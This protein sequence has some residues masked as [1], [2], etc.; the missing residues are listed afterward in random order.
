MEDDDE[1]GDLYTDVLR[2]FASSSSSS[3]PQPHQ[4]SAAPEQSLRR[5]ID[6]SLENDDDDAILGAP[7]SNPVPSSRARDETLAPAPTPGGA[8]DSFSKN[9]ITSGEVVARPRVLLAS[10][11]VKLRD[12]VVEVSNSNLNYG[13]GSGNDGVRVQVG[14]EDENLMD[15]DVTFD[16]EEG[17]LGIEDVGSEPVIPGLESSAPIRGS[18][19]DVENVEAAGRDRSMGGDGFDD[20]EDGIGAG[21]GAG[22]GDDWDSDSE[23]DLQIVLND[24][25]HGHLAMERDGLE[26]DE[27]DDDEDGLVIVADGDPNQAIEEQDWGEDAGQV[28]DGERKEMGEAGKAGAGIVVP[29]KIGYSNH[30]YHPFHS[31]FKVSV[32]NKLIGIRIFFVHMG[33]VFPFL[34]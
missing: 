12:G 5:P 32:L 8:A 21:A 28:A 15:K 26:G 33:F 23:D 31:Q 13:V 6:L 19:G 3:A 29:P 4:T 11:D 30:N 20:D 7:S 10:G 16:I 34:L 14:G 1:F 25:N 27:D 18:S 22:A 17:N 2:P 9:L 24:N